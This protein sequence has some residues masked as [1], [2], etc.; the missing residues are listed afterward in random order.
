MKYGK[1]K[2]SINNQNCKTLVQIVR[3]SACAGAFC[4]KPWFLGSDPAVGKFNV[5]AGWHQLVQPNLS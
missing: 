5:R 4:T 3:L 2:I 1:N